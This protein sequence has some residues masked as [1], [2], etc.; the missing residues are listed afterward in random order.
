M[1]S[2]SYSNTNDR[3][4][5]SLGLV[6]SSQ[7]FAL[8]YGCPSFPKSA[9]RWRFSGTLRTNSLFASVSSLKLGIDKVIPCAIVVI[10]YFSYFSYYRFFTVYFSNIRQRDALV[11]SVPLSERLIYYTTAFCSCQ[12]LFSSF[13]K[14]FFCGPLSPSDLLSLS[15]FA[16][17][18]NT[19]FDKNHNKATPHFF[20]L[21]VHFYFCTLIPRIF[22][23]FFDIFAIYLFFIVSNVTISFLPLTFFEKGV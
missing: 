1:S 17:I 15:S 8:S 23:C 7:T 11:T 12:E 2:S 21:F 13:F 9:L 18:V 3:C 5:S 14:N 20:P 16:R 6:C 22:F 19:F 4:N 10:L